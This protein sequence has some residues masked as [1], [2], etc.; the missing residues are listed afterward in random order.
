MKQYQTT[1]QTISINYALKWQCKFANHYKWSKC[2]KLF[3]MKT[4]K[5]IKKTLNGGSIGYWIDGKFYTVNTLRHQVVL[6]PK[7]FC[8]F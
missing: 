1:M 5:Q 8:P 4:A 7:E 6:I 3:N 2:G